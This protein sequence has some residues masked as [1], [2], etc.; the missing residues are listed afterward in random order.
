MS[1]N[2]IQLMLF[3][4]AVES[5]LLA[6]LARDIFRPVAMLLM[7]VASISFILGIAWEIIPARQR[8]IEWLLRYA[9]NPKFWYS[10]VGVIWVTVLTIRTLTPTTG[11]E[12]VSPEGQ[13]PTS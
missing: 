2:S 6:F 12:T 5:T 11:A 7:A 1:V 9:D 13:K 8:G 10:A 3:A 4:C